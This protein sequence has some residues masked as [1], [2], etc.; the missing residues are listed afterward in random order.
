MPL[1]V[2]MPMSGSA[3]P[4]R[5]AK[6]LDGAVG[7]PGSR[8]AVYGA[9]ALAT[10]AAAALGTVTIA[11]EAARPRN[12]LEVYELALTN[13]PI[14]RQAEA[15]Y[16]AIAEARPQAPNAIARA[17]AEHEAA[18]QELLIRV[19]EPYFD[20]IAA[21][22][23]LALQESARSS[24]SR[25]LEQFKRR[26]DAGLISITEMKESQAR[27]DQA[28]A[29]ELTAQGELATA[30]QALRDVV[31]EPVGELKPLVEDLPLS[32]PAP[33]NAE[34]WIE[35]ALAE[36]FDL[37]A[38]QRAPMAMPGAAIRP[39]ISGAS[40]FRPRLR[41]AAY[42]GVVADRARRRS[43]SRCRTC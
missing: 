17:T 31:G 13:D 27:F 25:Q 30:Q 29:N 16:R 12:L 39:R 23:G 35:T 38:H 11:Q 18:R 33:S 9:A 4:K 19:A 1:L 40:R 41:R 21:Q 15:E 36:S 34:Q 14:V 10:L 26:F 2:G 20:V 37:E 42:L 5:I 22:R 6:I 3:L 24:T 7:P 32:P 8:T 28:V 43:A